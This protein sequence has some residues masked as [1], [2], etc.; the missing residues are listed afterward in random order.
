M[1]NLSRIEKYPGFRFCYKIK[2]KNKPYTNPQ[3]MI[4]ARAAVAVT[5]TITAT[6]TGKDWLKYSYGSAHH[7]VCI[8]WHCKLTRIS[9]DHI[10]VSLRGSCWSPM[11]KYDCFGC[12]IEFSEGKVNP[13]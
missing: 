9:T 8:V 6:L 12:P 10:K 13:K 5:V 1:N 7:I 11:G 3:M 2:I 4:R